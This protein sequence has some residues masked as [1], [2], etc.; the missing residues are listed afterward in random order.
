M[1]LMPWD[2]DDEIKG[3]RDEMNRMFNEAFSQLP[4]SLTGRREAV[5]SP[6]IDVCQTDDAIIVEVELPGVKEEDFSLNLTKDTLKISG[7]IKS[8]EAKENVSYLRRER[9][10][11]KFSRTIALP[12]SIDVDKAKAV[13]KNGILQIT[14]PKAEEVKPRTLKIEVEK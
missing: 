1:S 7:E 10:R 11:G 8:A 9:H 4:S 14:L 13:Y 12:V 6:A 2:I 5:W 3:I